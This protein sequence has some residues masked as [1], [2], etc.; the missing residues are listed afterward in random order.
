[1]QQAVDRT[2]DSLASAFDTLADHARRQQ[3]LY[4]VTIAA[5]IAIVL[6]SGSRGWP[7]AGTSITAAA[8]SRSTWS[9]S[10]SCCKTNRPTC[11]A[12]C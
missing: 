6:F 8:T 3:H 11:S 2:R 12:P 9:R 1:M 7:R 4:S 5:L 10:R